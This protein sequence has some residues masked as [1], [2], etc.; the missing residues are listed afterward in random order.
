MLNMWGIFL[1]A[2]GA[3]KKPVNDAQIYGKIK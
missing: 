2:V 1:G 3:E